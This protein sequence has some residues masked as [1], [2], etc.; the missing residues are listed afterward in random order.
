MWGSELS[1]QGVFLA[2]R[3]LVPRAMRCWSVAMIVACVDDGFHAM[4]LLRRW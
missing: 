3:L 4:W 2:R 1:G